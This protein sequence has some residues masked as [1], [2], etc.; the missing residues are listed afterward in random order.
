[1]GVGLGEGNKV[2]SGW[3]GSRCLTTGRRSTRV[4]TAGLVQR[5]LP[6]LPGCR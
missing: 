5:C 3:L 1:M 4:G 2:Q 6:E